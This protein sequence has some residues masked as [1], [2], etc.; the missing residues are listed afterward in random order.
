VYSYANNRPVSVTVDGVN[1][2]NSVVYEPFGPN[3][4]WKWGNSAV[5]AVNTHTRVFDKDFRLTR[6]TSD[7]P[8]SGSQPYFDRQVG[9][10]QQSRV[11]SITD[12]ANSALSANYGFDAL[13]RV[14]SIAQG[15]SSWGYS[16]NGIGD[17]LTSTANAAST[18]YGY[19][20]GTHRL[21]SLSGAQTKS[22]VYDAAGNRTSDGT[23]TWVYGG[24]NRPT[25][26]GSLTILINAL[27][28]RVKKSGASTTRFVFDEAGH[29]WGE[30]TDAGVLI[31][32]TV[33]LDELPV[34]TLRP[35]G[36]GTDIYY[37]HP[38]H[39]GTPRAITRSTDNQ[40]V[41]KWDNTEAFGDSA[42]NES[43]SG[44]GT[45]AYNLRFRGQYFDGETGS[46]YNY[47]RDYEPT[48]GRYIQSDPIG[49]KGGINTFAYA[50]GS[51]LRW[52]DP[53]GLKAR[54]CCREIGA[55]LNVASHCF[56]DTSFGQFGLHGDMDPA[57]AGSGVPG[58]GRIRDDASFNDP[59]FSDCGPWTDN[60]D[61]DDCVRKTKGNY[62]D[63][64]AYNAPGGPNSNTFAGT[65]A[66]SCKLAKPSGPWA[67]GWGSTPR[68][69]EAPR[70]PESGS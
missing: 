19:F 16:Y 27:G 55:T 13:D 32:E 7:L 33:W 21:Q 60:C 42:P 59:K 17:R 2:L 29:L 65:I 23:T 22:Y 28:Q 69:Y 38:D 54:V 6:V 49:L 11:A 52:T 37:V 5:G 50:R 44:L 51:P 46:H 45:F 14:T 10:D 35:N 57:P 53:F 34:A 31:Q 58:Q 47:F 66:R 25:S 43:P 39:L 8:A 12:L 1:V 3:G 48:I 26:A 64:S 30:Y 70:P 67:P 56:I 4:G 40:F 24:N 15:S 18:T 61:T 62:P 36:S 9:W 20:S 63:P 41:W 68:P